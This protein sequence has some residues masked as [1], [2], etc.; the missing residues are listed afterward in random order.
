VDL[1]YDGGPGHKSDSRII[2]LEFEKNL[3]KCTNDNFE[4]QYNPTII[5]RARTTTSD[6]N[7]CIKTNFD[8]DVYD[9]GN[10][11]KHLPLVIC[12]ELTNNNKTMSQR[13]HQ[14]VFLNDIYEM[15]TRIASFENCTRTVYFI[16]FNRL[17]KYPTSLKRKSNFSCSVDILFQHV[18]STPSLTN[19]PL[20]LVLQ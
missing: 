3:Y 20:F 15:N 13:M 1:Q 14:Q 10:K 8:E 2:L 12:L 19:I 18:S 6:S 5:S 11:Y 4:E 9:L 7:K 16:K 17:I